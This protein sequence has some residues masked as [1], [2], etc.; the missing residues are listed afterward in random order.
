MTLAWI[1]LVNAC[2]NGLA[3][4]LLIAG[5]LQIRRG[6]ERAHARLMG[7]AVGVSALFLVGY[8]GHKAARALLDRPMHTHFNGEGLALA[9]YYAVLFSH[10]LLAMTVPVF[11]VTLVILGLLDKRRAHRRVAAW[12]FPIWLYVSIT[13]VVIYLLLYPLN[14]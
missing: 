6:R 13:G 2:L 5:R 14:P 11:A 4:A 12:G 8:V 9:G 1:P 7:S 3:A 10:L